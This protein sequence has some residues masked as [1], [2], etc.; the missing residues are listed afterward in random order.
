MAGRNK[1]KK[2]AADMQR[3]EHRQ[4]L[5]R[6]D[7]WVKVAKS[8]ISGATIFGC[9]F[10]LY[11]TAN[12]LAGKTT[13]VTGIAQ[14]FVNL[15]MSEWFAYGIASVTGVGWYAERRLRRKTIK[16]QGKHI[17]EL[18]KRIDPGRSSSGLQEDGQ[19]KPE[20]KDA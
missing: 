10:C 8:L 4:K 18:E 20:D 5:A 12:A 15:R 2:I 3:Q 7:G 16:G 6:I 14:A 1:D 17:K 11:L 9:F 13:V 19:P